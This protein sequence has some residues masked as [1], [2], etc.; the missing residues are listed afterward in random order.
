MSSRRGERPNLW[1]MDADGQHPLQLTSDHEFES[2]PEWSSDGARILYLARGGDEE[3]V[4]ALDVATR[5][6]HPIVP[7]AALRPSSAAAPAVA[8]LAEVRLSR[9]ATRV[10]FSLREPPTGRRVL[11]ATGLEPLSPHRLTDG[12]T[13]VGYPSWSPDERHIA[14]EMKEGSSTH[15]GVIDVETG[16]LR[17]LTHA[18]GQ[19]WVRSWS[20]DGSRLAAA[21]LRDGQWSLRALDLSGRE[22]MITSP[23]PPRVFVR[24]PDWSAR[25]DLI[26]F[27]R[28]EM[29]GNIWT[30]EAPSFR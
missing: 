18:S 19:T 1:M 8:P 5:T 4:V 14:V 6:V 25:G 3:R 30:M 17:R 24:Y 16:A 12:S 15:A 13:S 23:G 26:V 10:A 29:T 11:Y 9:S 27:E 21:V 22:Q 2:Q 20:P 7:L 28:S